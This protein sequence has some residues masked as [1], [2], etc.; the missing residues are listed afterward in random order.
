MIIFRRFLPFGNGIG[1]TS[2]IKQ[3]QTIILNQIGFWIYTNGITSGHGIGISTPTS[4][5]GDISIWIFIKKGFV[6]L[7]REIIMDT[8]YSRLNGFVS[9]F[10]LI[11]KV[12]NNIIPLNS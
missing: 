5:L 4:I 6:F 12:G 7:R 11:V 2:F 10:W 9:L 1:K 3:I 8:L